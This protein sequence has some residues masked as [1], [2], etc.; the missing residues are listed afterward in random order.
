[1]GSRPLTRRS[2]QAL[3]MVTVSLLAMSGMVGL[4]V[5]FGWSYFMRRTQQSAADAA[6]M[7]AIS[8]AM[9]AVHSGSVTFSG[10]VNSFAS[11]SAGTDCGNVANTYLL[12]A[13]SYASQNGFSQNVKVSSD[14]TPLSGT[15]GINN[16]HCW[17]K[18]QISSTIPQLYSA[19]LGNPNATVAAKATAAIVDV[20]VNGA[21]I[22]LNRINDTGT[23]G[24]PNTV[25]LN[26]AAG[27][28]LQTDIGHGKGLLLSSTD[29]GSGTN[30]GR[31]ATAFT[32]TRGGLEPAP[33]NWSTPH[34]YQGDSTLFT[35]PMR[36]LG[37][38]PIGTTPL[39]AYPV[40]NGILNNSTFANNCNP[41]CQPGVYF[42]VDA[43]NHAYGGAIT[44]NSS[45][46]FSG[47]SFGN[48]VFYGGL[49]VGAAVNMG[50]G[51]YVM[52][53]VLNPTNGSAPYA[54]NLAS[55]GSLAG[56][57]ASGAD[58]G[59]LII[60]TR[61][62]YPNLSSVTQ[63]ALQPSYDPNGILSSLKFG[64]TNLGDGSESVTLFGLNSNAINPPPST[65]TN[66][67]QF[68]LN[69]FG[70]VVIWQDQRFSDVQYTSTG[71]IACAGDTQ[72]TNSTPVDPVMT[73]SLTSSSSLNG[74]LYQPRGAWLNVLDNGSAGARPSLQGNLQ[75]IS[76]A[77]N[78]KANAYVKLLGGNDN[79]GPGLNQ[80]PALTMRIPALV[81]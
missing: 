59:H 33:S 50:P 25:D 30:N 17:V 22:G 53:G 68:S 56:T 72:C 79:V 29:P 18:V 20:T 23:N 4:A 28:K 9:D 52:A 44:I 26:L 31:V 70:P 3:I 32:M 21:V 1:M 48:F 47:G 76:G 38:P 12:E 39:T 6:A 43:M 46:T 78:L 81:Q 16:V 80:P 57:D 61:P 58:A 36:D 67:Q 74:I 71:N 64:Q 15:L 49:N 75:L 42:A 5:D 14:I 35:D 24:G 37:Q 11:N 63:S 34:T 41:T 27:S 51:V 40:P 65:P 19:I 69:D 10:A 77:V 8:A 55:G 73:V 45:V 62:D 60:L 13:C 7:A 66:S 54:L 2:G